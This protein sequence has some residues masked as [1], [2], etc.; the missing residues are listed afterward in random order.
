MLETLLDR[1]HTDIDQYDYNPEDSHPRGDGYGVRPE[2]QH[3]VDSLKFVRDGDKVVEPVGPTD[4]EA[5]SRV[6]E[7]VRPLHKGG[8]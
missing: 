5:S 2:H 8:W 1:T 7:L 4:G 6:D 3:S